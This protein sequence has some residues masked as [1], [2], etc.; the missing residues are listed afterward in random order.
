MQASAQTKSTAH[1]NQVWS[2]YA[3]QTR[4]SGRWGMWFDL[5]LRTGENFVHNFSTAII[6]PGIIYYFSD[7]TRFTA[8]YAYVNH[9]AVDNQGISVPEH[10]PWLQLAWMTRYTKIRTS[11]WVRLEDRFRR[12]LAANGSELAPGYTQ[13]YRFRYNLAVSVPL[14]S[15]S[16]QP[17]GWAFVV[18]DEVFINFGKEIVY[19]YFDQNR[20]FTGFYYQVNKT[21]NLQFGYLNVFSQTAAGNRFRSIHALR[22][23][24]I[25]SLDLR[26]Q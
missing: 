20:F 4:F 14:N 8:G 6:R 9:F 7:N 17:K 21:G 26:K 25:H 22:I 19:N 10:R 16:F 2:S 1:L 12:K 23:G 18:S 24:Y 13:N 3:N 5:Q 11:Q 15:K